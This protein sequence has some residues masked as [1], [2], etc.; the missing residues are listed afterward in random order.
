MK[1]FYILTTLAVAALVGFI[2]YLWHNSP[3]EGLY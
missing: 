3:V 1:E 2:T